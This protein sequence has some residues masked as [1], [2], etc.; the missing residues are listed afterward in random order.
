MSLQSN[1]HDRPPTPNLAYVHEEVQEE[2][3]TADHTQDF[4]KG[5]LVFR[6]WSGGKSRGQEAVGH[7]TLQNSMHSPLSS[8]VAKATCSRNK[9][10][11]DFNLEGNH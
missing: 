6:V 9:V 7:I 8:G 1:H 11:S 2:G 4:Q 10:N 5:T 3:A